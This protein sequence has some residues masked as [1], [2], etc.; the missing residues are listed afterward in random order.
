M[1]ILQI[2]HKVPS[3]E[4]WKKAFDS[5]PVGRKKSG[6]RRYQIFSPADDPNYVI[7]DLY[8]DNNDDAAKMLTSLNI[9]W[10]KVAGTVMTGPKARILN[11]VES[12]EI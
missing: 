3:F 10:G 11:I 5:D 12:V 8:F 9:L 7:I 6:V 2:E 4:G 1:I